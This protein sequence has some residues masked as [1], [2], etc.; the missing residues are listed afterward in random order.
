MSN[1]GRRRR[2]RGAVAPVRNQQVDR[3]QAD[4]MTDREALAREIIDSVYASTEGPVSD[5]AWA[6][7]LLHKTGPR[8]SFALSA[9]DVAYR[10][11]AAARDEGFRTFAIITGRQPQ[12]GRVAPPDA[13]GSGAG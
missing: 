3:H 5:G 10:H 7:M 1:A 12:D 13:A 11:I 2:A 8:I 6:K 4:P 9:A